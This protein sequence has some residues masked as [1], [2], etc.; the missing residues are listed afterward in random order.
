ML[1]VPCQKQ[2]NDTLLRAAECAIALA[3]PAILAWSIILQTLRS[4]TSSSQGEVLY[5]DDLSLIEDSSPSSSRQALRTLPTTREFTLAIRN[6][7]NIQMEEDPIQYLAMR[8]VNVCRALNVIAQM[9]EFLDSVLMVHSNA[10]L[11]V[12]GRLVLLELVRQGVLV[13][14]YTSE[15]VNCVQSLLTFHTTPVQAMSET[16]AC[17]RLLTNYFLHDEDLLM[18]G[19]FLQAQSRYPYELKPFLRLCKALEHDANVETNDF[20]PSM[21]LSNLSHFTQIMS[22]DFSAYEL[23]REDENANRIRLMEDLQLFRARRVQPFGI[24]QSNPST[25]LALA[26]RGTNMCIPRGTIG[27]VISE[28]KPFVVQWN[29][30]HSGLQYLAAVLSAGLPNSKRME[31]AVQFP[32]DEEARADTISLLTAR[33]SKCSKEQPP[34]QQTD[35]AQLVLEEASDGLDRNEDIISVV[36]IIFEEELSKQS[37][38]RGEKTTTLLVACMDFLRAVLTFLPG[39]VWPVIGR[40]GLLEMDGGGGTLAAVIA[41]VEIPSGRYDLLSSSLALFSAMIDDAIVHSV[42]RKI[43]STAQP[44]RFSSNTQINSGLTDRMISKI[45]ESFVRLYLDVLQSSANWKFVDPNQG[46]A[47]GVSIMRSFL[48]ILVSVYGF[49]DSMDTEQ[50]VTSTLSASAA[51]IKD[52]FLNSAESLKSLL[53]I[54]GNNDGS[55][56]ITML[57]KRVALQLLTTLL[58]ISRS[59]ANISVA[60]VSGPLLKAM[61]VF[62]RMYT[63]HQAL[64]HEIVSMMIELVEYLHIAAEEPPALLGCLSTVSA[65]AFMDVIADVAMPL[66]TPILESCIWEFASVVVSRKQQWLATYVLTG[67]TPKTILRATKAKTQ[68]DRGQSLLRIAL[69]HLSGASSISSS[70]A[71]PMLEFVASAQNHWAWITY[72]IANERQ[73]LTG[74]IDYVVNLDTDDGAVST[75]DGDLQNH[76]THASAIIAQILAMFLHNSRMNGDGFAL[77]MIS[78]KL[79]A[80]YR[81]HA[82][83]VPTYSSSLHGHLQ[84]NFAQKFP[85]CSLTSFKRVLQKSAFGADYFYDVGFASRLLRFHPSWTGS[86]NDGFRDEVIRANR[87]LSLVEAQLLQFK[88]WRSLAIEISAGFETESALQLQMVAVVNRCLQANSNSTLPEKVFGHLLLSRAA[89]ALITLQRLVACKIQTRSIK[90]V[91]SNVWTAI[92]GCGQNF[93]LAFVGDTTSYYRTLLK[94]LLLAIQP[95]IYMKAPRQPDTSQK[96]DARFST[97]IRDNLEDAGPILLEITTDVVAKG[98]HSLATTLHETPRDVMPSDLGL[99]TALLQSVLHIDGIHILHPQIALRLSDANAGRYAAALFSW[100]DHF[101]ADEGDPVFGELSIS[102]LVDMSCIQPQAEFLAAEGLLAQLSTANIMRAF[103]EGRGAGPLDSPQRLHVIWAKGILPLCLNLLTAVGESFAPE[104]AGFL[105]NFVAQLSRSK[106]YLDIKSAP[107]ALE[108]SAS[109]ITLNVATELH[110]L[111]LLSVIL[112]RFRAAP[113][114]SAIGEIEELAWDSMAVKADLEAWLN[115]RRAGLKGR[116]V[117]TTEQE[118]QMARMPPVQGNVEGGGD[119]RLVEKVISELAGALACLSV[120]I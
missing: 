93:E 7:M 2:I 40:C 98:F 32:L 58:R 38:R 90:S 72:I 95:Y 28:S 51:L 42:Q 3:S 16:A 119:N 12:E 35:F 111:A 43:A 104:V 39:R 19:L 20:A 96:K 60:A 84:K 62:V 6:V 47:I 117:A 87:N 86:R 112:G 48:D 56:A 107:S 49:N 44:G 57:V 103:R 74:I 76:Q 66:Q 59:S 106:R 114:A 1:D 9:C 120:V 73:F 92:R 69:K 36:G 102:F 29:F 115:E 88:G 99:L 23:V 91:L 31:T 110:T 22:K 65:A 46:C 45:L 83:A 80:Y 109:R 17:R 34:Q 33:I 116:I 63:I 15:L 68:Y 13:V 71:I 85:D 25:I 10:H 55:S 78:I 113:A 5:D 26:D 18:P 50:K 54:C 75:L 94:I 82:L 100:S 67:E 118:V 52:M 64:R 108:P 61:P 24:T 101:T 89:L 21:S 77:K 105:N 8:A 79:I 70:R 53:S 11:L 81:E 97:S 30:A 14:E 41:S 37:Q 27:V 4:R